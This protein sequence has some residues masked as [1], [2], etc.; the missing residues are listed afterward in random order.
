MSKLFANLATGRGD[1]RYARIMRTISGAQLLILDDWGLEPLDDA[2]RHDLLEILEE[3]YGR[4]STVVTSQIPVER[5]H[6]VIG[7]QTYADAIPIASSTTP[8][9]RSGESLQETAS[10]AR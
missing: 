2:G 4:T 3:R 6:E 8:P 9:L 1:G 5:W 7:N 10:L